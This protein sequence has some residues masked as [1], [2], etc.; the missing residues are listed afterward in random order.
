MYQSY[1]GMPGPPIEY[2]DT[3]NLSD[4]DP[5]P[6]GTRQPGPPPPGAPDLHLDFARYADRI[7]DLT[8]RG[9][10]LPPSAHP[11]P[12]PFCRRNS[13]LVFNVADYSRQL[14]NDFLIAGGRIETAEF[15]SP[16]DFAAII[17]QRTII[18]CTGYGSRALFSDESITPVRG[19][20]GWLIPQPD[21]HYAIYYNGLNMLARRDGIVMQTNPG[22][23]QSGW[24]S[25]DETP[26]RAEAEAGVRILQDLYAR[27]AAMPARR[28][29]S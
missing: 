24:N 23:E 13:T 20:I 6:R 2:M 17:P 8:P 25:T 1:L 11:F 10:D 12:T 28:S 18:A 27:M 22:G 7:A 21:A 15:H 29:A 5:G 9:Q 16:A 19:Q 14:L 26:N 4:R 3:Y